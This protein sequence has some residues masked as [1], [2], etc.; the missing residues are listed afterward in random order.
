MERPG[1]LAPKQ[2]KALQLFCVFAVVILG[3]FA[4]HQLNWQALFAPLDRF[5]YSLDQHY[6]TW[7]GTQTLKSPWVLIPLAFV[8]GL[9]ASISPCVLGLLPVNLSYIGT[10]EV[11][12]RKDA[13]VKASLFVL[14][15]VTAYSLLGLSSS[16]A[17][18]VMVNYRGYIQIAVGILVILM[19]L[20][21]L[22]VLQVPLPQ[23]SIRIPIAGSYGVGVTFAF[24]SSP[25]TSPVLFSVLALAAEKG[26][27]IYSPL[28]MVSYALGYT[29]VI[30]LASLFAGVLKQTRGLL[31][32]TGAIARWSSIG[33]ILIGSY[34][35][36][37]GMRWV[38]AMLA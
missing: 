5:I 20:M 22:G 15:V 29:M 24:V 37:D 9:I 31:P 12:S 10:R 36:A 8:G 17:G 4:L 25:C 19:G 2:I 18:A 23:T 30:F 35:F 26:S 21:L 1:K 14:G 16:L 13:L 38:W 34:Y 28:T 7:M 27:P 3:A 11:A 32:Y 6:H 33:L